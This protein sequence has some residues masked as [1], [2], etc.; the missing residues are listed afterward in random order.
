MDREA[1]FNGDICCIS[2]CML[3]L[4]I[5]VIISGNYVLD[6]VNVSRCG[7]FKKFHNN[8]IFGVC[9]FAKFFHLEFSIFRSWHAQVLCDHYSA[10]QR[11]IEEECGAFWGPLVTALMK[12][13]FLTIGFIGH[14]P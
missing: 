8:V 9:F 7:R 11:E 6:R 5:R 3:L 14:I 10:R 1:P 13:I 12:W 4:V 2:L